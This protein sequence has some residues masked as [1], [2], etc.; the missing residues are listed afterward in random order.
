MKQFLTSLLSRKLWL[1]VAA[2][3]GFM[4]TKQYLEAMG[5]VLGY[6]GVNVFEKR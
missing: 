1:T 2:F 6:L 4:A 5:V 3:A